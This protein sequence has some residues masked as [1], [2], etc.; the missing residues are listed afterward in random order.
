MGKFNAKKVPC[1]FE[2][3]RDEWEVAEN[4]A[5]NVTKVRI[6]QSPANL[7]IERSAGDVPTV[8]DANGRITIWWH[9]CWHVI[10]YWTAWFLIHS[11]DGIYIEYDTELLKDTNLYFV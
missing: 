4:V 10:H 11:S 5:E 1:S 3:K 9:S 6:S 8:A 2:I 7:L